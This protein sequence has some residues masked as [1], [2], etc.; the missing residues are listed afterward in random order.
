MS[1]LE[2]LIGILEESIRKDGEE[3]LTNTKLLYFLKQAVIEINAEDEWD[4]NDDEDTWN[5]YLNS[6]NIH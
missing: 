1:E 5:N 6:L 3:L 4:E 2:K